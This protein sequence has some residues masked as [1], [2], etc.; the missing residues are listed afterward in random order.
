[1]VEKLLDYSCTLSRRLGAVCSLVVLAA[2]LAA[3]GGG[4]TTAI[5]SASG[6][7]GAL[8]TPPPAPP[9]S[10][11]P[12]SSVASSEIVIGSAL[13]PTPALT[14]GKYDTIALVLSEKAAPEFLEPGTIEVDVDHSTN[15]YT[16]AFD[17]EEVPNVGRVYGDY[18]EDGVLQFSIDDETYG[19][20]YDVVFKEDGKIESIESHEGRVASLHGYIYDEP[21]FTTSVGERYVS[22]GQWSWPY[23]TVDDDGHNVTGTWVNGSVTYVYGERTPPGAIPV[24]GTATYSVPE[25]AVVFG[26]GPHDFNSY[27]PDNLD[28][29]LTADFGTQS[30]AAAVAYDVSSYEGDA[31]HYDL[32]GAAPITGSGDFDISL[33]GS[34]LAGTFLDGIF[35]PGSDTATTSPDGQLVGAFFG[36]AADQIGG[37]MAIPGFFENDTFG[38]AFVA[39]KP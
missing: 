9:A 3:C 16:F 7:Q 21:M 14:T 39:T 33:G 5:S 22:L 8:S 23:T 25:G 27:G 15:T 20:N 29:A 11:A 17:P 6:A 36:P 26:E 19:Y 31:F 32:S 38:V 12:D 18:P 1:M 10:S 13:D 28:I 4:G 35:A 24:S 30:I 34:K 37:V 2:T